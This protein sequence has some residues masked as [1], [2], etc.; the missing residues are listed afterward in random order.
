MIITYK[1]YFYHSF[2]NLSASVI[3]SAQVSFRQLKLKNQS[4]QYQRTAFLV[5]LTITLHL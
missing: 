5:R 1:M 4:N 3:L 2:G